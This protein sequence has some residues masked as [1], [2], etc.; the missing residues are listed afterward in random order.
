MKSIVTGVGGQDGHYMVKSLLSR[1]WDVLGV[2][3]NSATLEALAQEFTSSQFTATLLDFETPNAVEH[4][5]KEHLPD[6]FFNF[7]AL[8][9]GSGMFSEP[10]KMS[11][12]NG[13]FA[14]DVLEAARLWRPE[15][16]I[17]Q[18][19]SAEMYGDSTSDSENERSCFRP[20]SPYGAAKLFA[21][22]MIGIYRSYYGIHCSSAILFNHESIRRPESFVTKKIARAA[23][24][25]KL[26]IRKTLALGSLETSRDWGFAPEY[27]D[28]MFLM[29]TQDVPND[30]VVGTGTITSIRYLCKTAF[31]H[32]NLDYNDY[33]VLDSNL[34]RTIET[35]ALRANPENIF[36]DLGWRAKT[37]VA[38]VMRGM[39]D[40][41][42]QEITPFEPV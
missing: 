22:N 36:R 27:V 42:M 12:I 4:L 31:E 15:M 34:I 5:I 39:V 20:K 25:I 38:E 3:S 16:R 18:A 19:S 26:G 37:P 24:Q 6:A 7:A 29:A 33:V 10:A 23:A 2:T 21:H 35:K 13:G 14:L 30:Y 41:E 8:A 40:F 17:C 9:T 11:R 28:A 1:G 32:L